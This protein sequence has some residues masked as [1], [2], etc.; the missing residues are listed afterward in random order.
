LGLSKKL[1]QEP[2][3]PTSLPDREDEFFWN[4]DKTVIFRVYEP[5]D[6]RSS[7]CWGYPGTDASEFECYEF[8]CS[9]GN[10][11]YKSNENA[12]NE[13]PIKG[14]S[15]LMSE[16]KEAFCPSSNDVCI[17]R[18]QYEK[19]VTESQRAMWTLII[20][21]ILFCLFFQEWVLSWFIDI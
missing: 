1:A 14:G 9:G 18:I 16:D 4:A 20:G 15:I 2:S 7:I 5:V 21:A 6:L 12:W 8:L 3:S 13:C 19:S 17:N 10:I 11:L